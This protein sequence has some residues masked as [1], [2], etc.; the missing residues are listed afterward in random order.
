MNSDK[1]L[2]IIKMPNFLEGIIKKHLENWDILS[3]T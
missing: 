2:Y 3:K 1:E